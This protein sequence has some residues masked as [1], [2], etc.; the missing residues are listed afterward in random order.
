MNMC[1]GPAVGQP[2]GALA[3]WGSNRDSS[4]EQTIVSN[5]YLF[6]VVRPVAFLLLVAMPFAPSSEHCS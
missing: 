2:R 1:L 6:L 5:S 3:L 4:E